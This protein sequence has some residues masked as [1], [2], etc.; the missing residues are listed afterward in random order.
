MAPTLVAEEEAFVPEEPTLPS[1]PFVPTPPEPPAPTEMAAPAAVV[2]PPILEGRDLLLFLDAAVFEQ[3][4]GLLAEGIVRA[5]CDEL[6]P[7][8]EGI[9]VQFRVGTTTHP[10]SLPASWEPA[11]QGMVL[12]R[13]LDPAALG[14]AVAQ[15][16]E[17][18]AH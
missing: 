2:R 13:F 11:D 7:V 9:W 5:L 3:A 18:L 1:V 15:I 14:E 16:S 17:S 6:P 4:R 10:A 12:L 8:D